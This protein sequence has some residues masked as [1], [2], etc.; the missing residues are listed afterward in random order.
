M[1]PEQQQQQEPP[2]PEGD[3]E[4]PNAEPPPVDVDGLTKALAA[5][6]RQRRDIAAQLKKLQQAE[7]ERKQA[8]M[9]EVDRLKAQLAEA[10]SKLTQYEV[11]ELRRKVAAEVGIP[12][13]LATRLAGDD[14]DAMRV[15]AEALKS[16]LAPPPPPPPPGQEKTGAGVGGE[17]GADET[18]PAKLAAAV[19]GR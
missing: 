18:D 15:D 6:R 16:Q 3:S 9:T 17:S 12:D 19:L 4:N 13:A 11:N 2:A 5:E 10:T 1:D 14:E 7:D 8:E